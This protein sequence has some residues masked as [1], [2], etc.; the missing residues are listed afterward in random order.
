MEFSL[1]AILPLALFSFFSKGRGA[2]AGIGFLAALAPVLASAVGGIFNRR[3][4]SNRQQEQIDYERAQAEQQEAQR[5][6]AF[7]AQQSGPGAAMSRLGFNTRLASIL[8]SFGG[9]AQTPEFIQRA[10]DSARQRQE[11][12]PGAGI[13]DRPNPVGGGFG[14]YLGDILNPRGAAGYFDVQG[15]NRGR[16]GGQPEQPEQ[17]SAGGAPPAAAG[18][19]LLP[20]AIRNQQFQLGQPS[21]AESQFLQERRQRP[22][23]PGR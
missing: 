13:I 5:R 19:G 20:S 12:T 16:Q 1:F 8:G 15:Y 4:T 23:Y 2:H 14:D 3:G 21:G 7:E 17:P 10:F 18:Q 11:Y 6:A 9:R 22:T